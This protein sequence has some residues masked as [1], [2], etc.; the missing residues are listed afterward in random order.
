[1][2]ALFVLFFLFRATLF[3]HPPSHLLFFPTLTSPLFLYLMLFSSLCLLLLPLLPLPVLALLFSAETFSPHCPLPSINF[4]S[5]ILLPSH[6]PPVAF[7]PHTHTHTFCDPPIFT[8]L[9]S[10]Y[11]SPLYSVLPYLDFIYGE[12]I[13]MFMSCVSLVL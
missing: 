12:C 3:I 5:P 10:S 13:L 6:F 8:F 4:L 7:P 11:F 1:M 9:S 2:L